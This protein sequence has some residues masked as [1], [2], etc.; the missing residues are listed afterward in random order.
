MPPNTDWPMTIARLSELLA[1]ETLDL[2]SIES[3]PW[4]VQKRGAKWCVVK[5]GTSDSVGCHDTE[6]GARRQQRALYARGVMAESAITLSDM[7]LALELEAEAEAEVRGPRW[8]GPLGLEGWPTSDG[9]MLLPGEIEERALP[10]PLNYQPQTDEQHKGSYCVG[11][12]ESV[13]HI[14]IADLDPALR[15]E[16]GL[17]GDFNEKTVVIWAE[18]T[19][20]SPDEN[21][22][23]DPARAMLANGAGVS[24]DLARG[25]STLLDPETHEEI[26]KDEL[27]L[28]EQ[29]FGEFIYGIGGK[30]GGV[31]IVTLEAIEEASIKVVDEDAVM[32]AS[33]GMIHFVEDRALVASAAPLKPLKSWFENPNF[34]ELTPCTITKD[35]QIFGHLA[36]WNGCHIGL[37]HNVCTPPF[38]SHTQYQVVNSTCGAGI[39][40]AEGDIVPCG[41]IMFSRDGVGHAPLDPSMSYQ[42]VQKWYDDSTKVAA[43][44]RYGEDRFG[45]WFAGALRS[46]LT[47]LEVQHIRTHP[48]S[49]DWRPVKGMGDL[50][51]SFCVPIGGFPIVT[52]QALVASAGG[53]LFAI[54]TAPLVVTDR[55]HARMRRMSMLSQRLRAALGPKRSS[56][57]E[58]RQQVA[59]ERK[60]CGP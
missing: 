41:K 33:G 46:D 32:V 31:T 52:P 40:T 56:R 36:D 50:I 44:V 24:L 38:R 16:F 37:S 18:G 26:D 11:R 1:D 9:R 21:E 53:E 60:E 59:S 15:E 22:H 58:L 8:R 17:D 2:E 12:I 47:D 54:I 51:A 14:P 30:I 6:A 55:P 19:F 43:F 23:V 57:A 13:E 27:T 45:T 42:Q 49:G 10:R 34:T 48:P 29:M 35:G 4:T 28:E 5:E 7:S 39:E 20:D 25:R 3:F